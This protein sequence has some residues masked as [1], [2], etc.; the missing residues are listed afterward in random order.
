MEWIS[1]SIELIKSRI[2]EGKKVNKQELMENGIPL[3]Y[4]AQIEWAVNTLNTK[5]EFRR[6]GIFIV[7][8]G[9]DKSGKET[10][11]FKGGENIK[12]IS[13]FLKEHG[14]SVMDIIQPSYDTILGSMVKWYLNSGSLN[15]EDAWILWVLDRAQ[16]NQKIANWL[17]N[18]GIVLAKRWTESNIVY[19]AVQGVNVDAILTTERNIVKQDVTFVLDVNLSEVLRRMNG[20]GDYYENTRMLNQVMENYL[21]LRSSYKYGTIVYV[22]ANGSPQEVNR[23][24]LSIVKDYLD[25]NLGNPQI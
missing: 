21:K 14:Y 22:D 5:I 12:P 8:S 24:L 25:A 3:L 6:K 19:Q 7:I 11:A 4:A 9:I 13:A 23:T 18:G 10:Q 15:R 16:H 2:M 1:N 20:K 17:S